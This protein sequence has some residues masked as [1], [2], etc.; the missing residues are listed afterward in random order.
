[1][2]LDA[3]LTLPSSDS[4]VEVLVLLRFHGVAVEKQ[5]IIHQY[6]HTIGVNEI[7]RCAKDLKLKARLVERDWAQLGAPQGLCAKQR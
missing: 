6:G 1:M 3:D 7:L 5:Q 2:P 4:G